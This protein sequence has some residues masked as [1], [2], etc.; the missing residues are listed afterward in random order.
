[1]PPGSSRHLPVIYDAL[2]ECNGSGKR[3]NDYGIGVGNAKGS[4]SVDGNYN[5]CAS[6]WVQTVIINAGAMFLTS[7]GI[8]TKFARSSIGRCK[9]APHNFKAKCTSRPKTVLTP[10]LASELVV[11]CKRL[12]VKRT[13]DEEDNLKNLD[14]QLEV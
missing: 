9:L 2:I 8:D 10:A 13:G 4:N 3:N 1:M 14:K 6:S 7:T 5:K 12:S 11:S